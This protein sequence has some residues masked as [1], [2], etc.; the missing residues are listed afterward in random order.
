VDVSPIT[1][2]VHCGDVFRASNS[3]EIMNDS[4]LYE[5]TRADDSDDDRPI[6]EL[7]DSDIEMLRRIVHGRRDPR[8]HEFSDL[9][10][11]D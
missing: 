10:H 2:Q 11:F 4:G 7:T 8:V 6:G 3:V 9:V 1:V 5:I